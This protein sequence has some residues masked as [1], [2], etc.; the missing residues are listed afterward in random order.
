MG[1]HDEHKVNSNQRNQYFIKKPTVFFLHFLFYR[2]EEEGNR[3]K[4]CVVFGGDSY[5]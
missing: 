4:G 2:V 5:R 3:M 1:K